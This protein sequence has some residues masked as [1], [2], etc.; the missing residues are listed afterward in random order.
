MRGPDAPKNEILQ[1]AL[2][3]TERGWPVFPCHPQ[4][5][6]PVTDNGLKDASKDPATVTE[7]FTRMPGAMVGIRTGAE[8]GIFV[9]DCDLAE[10]IDGAAAFKELFPD[11]PETITV[12]TPR[13]GVHYYFA[14]PASA[15]I[16]NSAGKIAPG[17]DVRG[18]GGYVIA[19]GSRRSD[20]VYYE[21]LTNVYP[22]PPA[23]PQRLIDLI[24]N[25][26]AV[27]PLAELANFAKAAASQRTTNG[28]GEGYGRAAL[29]D[30]CDRVTGAP[31]GSRN[32]QLNSS[33]FSLGQLVGGGVLNESEVRDRLTEAA[34][35]LAKDDGADSVRN[36]ISSGLAAGIAQPRTPPEHKQETPRAKNAKE[37]AEP[38]PA[39]P[40]INMSKWD[41]EPVPEQEWAVLNRIPLHQCVLFSGE[42]AT[43]KSTVELHRAATHVL[44]R[45]PSRLARH[46][47]GTGTGDICRCRRR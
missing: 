1:V 3:C 29:D 6:R 8:S 18:E 4:T 19:A 14:Y 34:A 31:V 11:L 7:W 32:H 23:A 22:D 20:G 47:A 9:I 30:E 42:G 44:A 45:D 41:D 35:S 43:G 36:T 2:R 12:R 17:V 33:A 21:P 46:H 27:T 26:E 25:G 16:R 40:W 37:D 24:T 28:S 38:P 15:E 5:K 10:D 13:N 39:L